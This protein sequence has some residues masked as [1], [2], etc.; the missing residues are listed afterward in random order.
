MCNSTS[1][2]AVLLQPSAARGGR[3]F[4][5]ASQR[6]AD[7]ARPQ[8]AGRRLLPFHF[9]L[10]GA[11][12]FGLPL[13]AEDD[14]ALVFLLL[15]HLSADDDAR[16]A[17]LPLLPDPDDDAG[18]AVTEGLV[19]C[20]SHLAT[21]SARRG[22]L[23]GDEL[24]LG[25]TTTATRSGAGSSGSILPLGGVG[26]GAGRSALPKYT[27]ARSAGVAMDGSREGDETLTH[28]QR[29]RSGG[30]SDELGRGD[31]AERMDPP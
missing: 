10:D 16:P 19:F 18:A 8:T 3:G 9:P 6:S 25:R 12:L 23:G 20:A 15:S 1:L 13:L 14:V 24:G 2:L 5:C 21:A 30:A 11:G 4:L 22:F 28:Q 29:S 31:E 27:R 17:G 7:G 26:S